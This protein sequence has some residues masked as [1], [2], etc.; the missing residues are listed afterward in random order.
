[1]SVK[2]QYF[3]LSLKH[4]RGD[5]ILWWGPDC[6]GYTRNLASAGIYDESELVKKGLNNGESTLAVL[7]SEVNS[8]A[9]RVVPTDIISEVCK[10][11]VYQ[12]SDGVQTQAVFDRESARLKKEKD[13]RERRIKAGEECPE[14]GSKPGECEPYCSHHGEEEDDDD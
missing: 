9:W 5:F 2:K 10:Q 3:I 6:K 13:E 8:K 4:T 1:M 12:T 14:C 11:S 7:C